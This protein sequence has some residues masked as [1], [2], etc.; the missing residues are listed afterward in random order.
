LRS[1]ISLHED[2]RDDEPIEVSSDRAFG[3]TVGSVLMLIAAAKALMA[4]MVGLTVL[5][6]FSAGAALLLLGV[7]APARL[8]TLNRLWMKIGAMMA[9]VVNPIVLALLFFLVVTPVGALMRLLGKRPLRLTA[10]P[11]APSY[12]IERMQ[13]GSDPSSMKRRF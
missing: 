1:N 8:S 4:G 11:D 5:L 12:W 10:E 13:S 6:I 7:V 3:C 2:F 9:R